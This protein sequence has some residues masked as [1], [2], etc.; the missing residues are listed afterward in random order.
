MSKDLVIKCL[1][2]LTG[3]A[4][5]NVKA[6]TIEQQVAQKIMIDLRYFCNKQTNQDQPCKKPLLILPD[7]LKAMISATNLGG[8][9]LFSENLQNIEQITTL[10]HDLQ[11][12]AKQSRVKSPLLISIDQ[13]GGRVVRLPRNLATSFTGNMS[14]GATYVTHGDTFATQSATVIAKELTA[15]GINVN[16]AP[17]IDVN[18]NP[19]NPVI[20]VRSFGEDPNKVAHLGAAQVRAFQQ[21]NLVATLKHFPGHG[22][23]NVDSHTGLPLVNHDLNTIYN[24]DLLPFKQILAQTSPGMI[25]TAHIQYPALDKTTFT[26]KNGDIM[27]KPATMSHK[28]LTTLLRD[29]MHYQG[30]VITDALNMAGISDFFTPTQAVIN[31]FKAG[32]DIA[33]MPIQ[34][35]SSDDVVKLEQLIKDVAN[36]VKSGEIDYLAFS[37]SVTRIATLKTNFSLS[38]AFNT[39]LET[40]QVK[41]K[42]TL[43][44]PVHLK[45]EKKLAQSAITL[46]KNRSATLPITADKNKKIHLIM[47]D[48]NKCVAF[49]YFLSNQGENNITVTCTSLIGLNEKR[50]K[51]NILNADIIISANISPK[52][53]VV[54]IGGMDDIEQVMIHQNSAL[55]SNQ[56]EKFMILAKT[57]NKPS[58]F[59]SLRAPYDVARFGVYAD[60]VLASYAYNVN[61]SDDGKTITSAAF[62]AL[63]HALLGKHDITGQ[64]PVTIL[65]PSE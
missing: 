8:I 9:I 32:A 49:S 46:I 43:A 54:E 65:Q 60:A 29:E 5:L 62:S 16:H 34:I 23:T 25:M 20:N 40:L 30:V 37:Q 59:I 28:I 10:T 45:I 26:A 51:A 15:L 48:Q 14:I 22:D 18:I 50:A 24:K 11:S 19:D 13:E 27:I 39:K 64:L 61:I 42:E 6:L 53:S 56:L 2:L 17:D 47:P 57:A 33:L 36:A 35:R 12:A 52:Q 21:H 31:T 3:I 1:L 55:A 41:A 58:I 44:N 7:E 63:A 38:D 4:S